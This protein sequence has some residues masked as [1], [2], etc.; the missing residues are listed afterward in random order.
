MEKQKY[1]N[2]GLISNGEFVDF[3]YIKTNFGL[4][5]LKTMSSIYN[6]NQFTNRYLFTG[7][8]IHHFFD[9]DTSFMGERLG[10]SFHK[11]SMGIHIKSI[12]LHEL[13]MCEIQYKPIQLSIIYN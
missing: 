1:H 2:I 10:H 9:C 4:N 7:H 3:Y 8:F 11:K 5:D 12:Q 13:K 6:W